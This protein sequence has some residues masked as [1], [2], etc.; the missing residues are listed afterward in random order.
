MLFF[1]NSKNNGENIM[2]E[3][4]KIQSKIA[5]AIGGIATVIS[6]LGVDQLQA[7]FPGFGKYIPMIVALATWYV[8]QTTENTRVERA[9][10]IVREEYDSS[11]QNDE[12]VF[13]NL[14][15]D[16]E[17]VINEDTEDSIIEDEEY[18]D[19]DEGC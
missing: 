6:I 1:L 12:N 5:T 2:V 4:Y 7:I 18:L 16:G 14:T 15:L 19:D 13:V 11:T 17:D 8:S 9:E 3:S 10:Q